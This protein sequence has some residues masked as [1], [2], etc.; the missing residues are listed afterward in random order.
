MEATK[1]EEIT[2]NIIALIEKRMSVFMEQK[3][4]SEKAQDPKDA[5]HDFSGTI[6]HSLKLLLI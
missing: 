6:Q 4:V 3:R 1:W 5:G 2:V